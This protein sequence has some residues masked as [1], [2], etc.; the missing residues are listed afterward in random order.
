MF[1]GNNKRSKLEVIEHPVPDGKIPSRDITDI[2]SNIFFVTVEPRIYN[3]KNNYWGG[4]YL[5]VYK[6]YMTGSTSDI[7]MSD[8]TLI[9][10]TRRGIKNNQTFE[11]FDYPERKLDTIP[12]TIKLRDNKDL[13]R[14]IRSGYSIHLVKNSNQYKKE[15][16]DYFYNHREIYGLED[17]SYMD[18]KT[19]FFEFGDSTK[20]QNEHHEKIHDMLKD[21]KP[22]EE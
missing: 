13:D 1:K 7:W 6:E 18:I 12:S 9:L 22:E 21:L 17:K 11:T 8:G 19:E 14:L 4:P 15:L 10:Y 16:V 2:P 3:E 20:A 5:Y